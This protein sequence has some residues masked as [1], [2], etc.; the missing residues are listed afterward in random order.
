MNRVLIAAVAAALAFHAPAAAESV[1]VNGVELYYDVRGSGEPLIL[2]HGFGMCAA[3]W[4]PTAVELAK[5]YRVI[6]VDARGHGRSTNPSNKF[7]HRQAAEDV[8]AL[9]DNLGIAQARAIGF[10]SGGMTLLQLSTSHPD[11]L[12]KMVVVGAAYEFQ[13]QARAMLSGVAKDGLPP[14]VLDGF[15]KCATRGDGQVK[16]LV[17]QFSAFATST[18]DMNL[19]TADLAKVKASTLIVH[20]DRDEFFPVSIPVAMYG[21]ISKSALWIVPGGDHSPNAG[22]DD[23]EFVEVVGEFL[24]P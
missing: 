1:K 8:R 19:T 17:S 5:Q 7:S 16:D 2:L 14:P 18:N 3:E 22:A 12:S 24:K 11:R 21:A 15:R 4:A 23:E 9:M 13:E 6:T 10:S 20:G